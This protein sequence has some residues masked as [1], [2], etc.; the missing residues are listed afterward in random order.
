MASAARD[1]LHD[2]PLRR[3]DQIE[4][5]A[6]VR[7][8]SRANAD[9]RRT[10]EQGLGRLHRV[11]YDLLFSDKIVPAV[12]TLHL[13]RFSSIYRTHGIGPTRL[14]GQGLVGLL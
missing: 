9:E 14:Q 8:A 3:L 5:A 12:T 11:W 10:E 1:G 13:V 6:N 4:V 7:P 2:I